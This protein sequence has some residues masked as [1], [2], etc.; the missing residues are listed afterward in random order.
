MRHGIAFS[1]LRVCVVENHHVNLLLLAVAGD[2][3]QF[4]GTDVNTGRGLRKPLR[5]ALHALDIG[6]LG[7]KLQFVEEFGSLTG[8]LI[9]THDGDQYGTFPAVGS[10]P[11]IRS[12][13][14]VF[15]QFVFKF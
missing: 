9:V 8:V 10:R 12:L 13:I 4:A 2:L 3:L 7:Q 14:S 6:R 11:G 15:F 5:E 1:I